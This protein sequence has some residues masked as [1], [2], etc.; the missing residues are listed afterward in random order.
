M[1]N[2]NQKPK[3]GKSRS[4]P[5]KVVHKSV[6]TPARKGR[7][8]EVPGQVNLIQDAWLGSLS[9]P[10]SVHGVRIPDEIVAPSCTASFRQRFTV[11][12]IQDGSTGK[13]AAAVSFIPTVL[14]SFKTSTTYNSATG[15][16][17]FGASVSFDGYPSLVNL[18]RNYR[19][20]SAG[21][22]VYSTTAMAQNQGRNLC[23]FYP[24]NDRT[25][26]GWT[27][28]VLVSG[29]LIAENSEDS[30]INEQ[31]VCSTVW[32]PSDRDNYRY[33]RIDSDTSTAT[34]GSATY[35]NP[36]QCVW[37]ADGISSS[38]SF[39]VC[40]VLNIE[41]QPLLNSV[42]FIPI[43]PSFYNQK[44]MERALNS[45][46]IS[47]MFGTAT[48][49][50]IMVTQGSNN[51]GLSALAGQLLSNFGSGAAEFLTPFATQM[52]RAAA[53]VGIQ[54]AMSG[55]RSRTMPAYRSLL[56]VNG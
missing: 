56:G 21:L 39:E 52:G 53:S 55:L 46:L 43:F 44:A 15:S 4:R 36:G 12:A 2:G 54:A 45:R 38:A 18:G 28:T 7:K 40:V 41:F 50:S 47:S 33:H 9:D 32:V 31:M 48:P 5:A 49:E 8:R 25:Q 37:V 35:Y 13:Y 16:L 34:I 6:A 11:Q 23:A 24:G 1:N 10:W 19:V 29:M 20:V 30:P 22:A 14:N 26:P 42:S 27:S 51:L 17:G 3:N